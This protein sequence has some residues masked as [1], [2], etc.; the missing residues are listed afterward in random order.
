[1]Q[2]K[3]ADKIQHPFAIKPLQKVGIEAITLNIIMAIYDTPTANII[4]DG[5]NLK[6]F[7]KVKF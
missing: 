7:H 1:M 4:L 2:K 6:A 3:T 5:E